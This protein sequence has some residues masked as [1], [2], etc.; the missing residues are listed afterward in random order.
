MPRAIAYKSQSGCSQCTIPRRFLHQNP[1]KSE[2][3][4]LKATTSL[5]TTMITRKR[6]T[7]RDRAIL[8]HPNPSSRG[9]SARIQARRGGVWLRIRLWR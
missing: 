2:Q 3:I 1:R 7:R 9:G 5:T 8:M 4:Q 6:T